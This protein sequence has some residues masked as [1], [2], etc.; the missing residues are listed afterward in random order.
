MELPASLP[1]KHSESLVEAPEDV[2]APS[3]ST[4]RP[5]AALQQSRPQEGGLV[6]LVAAWEEELV[7]LV[8]RAMAPAPWVVASVLAWPLAVPSMPHPASIPCMSYY[9][10]DIL[11]I[12]TKGAVH[13]V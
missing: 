4:P 1:L 12:D 8:D 9:S 11:A 10:R 6:A 13:A 2:V 5:V 7:A 3:C